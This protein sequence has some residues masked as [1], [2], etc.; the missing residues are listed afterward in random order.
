[1]ARKYNQISA[2]ILKSLKLAETGLAI[3]ELKLACA[4]KLTEKDFYNYL[5]R[6]QSQELITKK[7]NLFSLSED[8]KKLLSHLKP[9]KDGVWKLIIFDIPE[10]QKKIRIILRSKL[11]QLNL[12]KWQ[13]SIWISPY[14]L[15]KAIEEE[16]NALGE[17]FFIRL[18]KTKEINHTKD[19]DKMFAE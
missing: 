5:F 16:L 12:K 18:I 8:G 3:T 4:P 17:K 14:Y 10:K 15:D 11:K 6:L 2:S 13:N 9:E 7:N 19:L 1:M